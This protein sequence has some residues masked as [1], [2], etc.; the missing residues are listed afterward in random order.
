MY[1]IEYRVKR[2]KCIGKVLTPHKYVDGT[3]VV[4]KTRF[5]R[6][7]VHVRSLREVVEHLDRGFKVRV[8]DAILRGT[9]SLVVRDSLNIQRF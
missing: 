6:D 3:Y 9:P 8:S 5:K 7:Y 2:G 4:S 1:K